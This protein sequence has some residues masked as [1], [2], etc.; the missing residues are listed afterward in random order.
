LSVSGYG[1]EGR[2]YAHEHDTLKA[3]FG[4]RLVDRVAGGGTGFGTPGLTAA[5]AHRQRLPTIG[6]LPERSLDGIAWCNASLIVGQE[7]GDEARVLGTIADA[8]LVLGG[9][10]IATEETRAAIH[11]GTPII[12]GQVKDYP[13]RDDA[14]VYM[15]ERDPD[16]KKALSDKQL[17]VCK[18]AAEIVAVLRR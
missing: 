9:G 2:P 12:M 18:S 6:V 13:R 1:T 16:A 7:F 11:A 17:V 5:L 14:A 10:P 3:V 8:H 15:H 4:S